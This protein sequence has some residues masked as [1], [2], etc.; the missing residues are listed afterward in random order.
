MAKATNSSVMKENNRRIILNL[1]R[2]GNYS[3]VDIARLTGLTKATV[4]ILTDEMLHQ[5]I[6]KE[7]ILSDYNSIGR[8]PVYLRINGNSKYTIGFALSRTGCKSGLYNLNGKVIVTHDFTY[9]QKTADEI[10]FDMVKKVKQYQAVIP[11][12]S[13]LGIGIASPGPVDYKKGIILNPPNFEKWHNYSI[14]EKLSELCKVPVVLENISNA[15]A[16]REMY[17]GSCVKDEN[18][19]YIAVDEGIGS[20]II[21]NGRIYRGENGYGNELGH[22]SIKYDGITCACGNKGCLECYAS[23]P[24][25]LKNTSYSSWRDVIDNNDTSIINREAEFLTCAIVTLINLFDLKTI[26]LGKD[27]NYK[28]DIIAK[29]INNSIKTRSIVKHPVEVRASLINDSSAGA[30]AATAIHKLFFEI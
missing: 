19:A 13:L 2:T 27:I 29:I 7:E 25:I 5:G 10:V 3:R 24:A 18:Y 4:T 1:I 12:G 14:C 21:I 15:L 9:S 6:I 22:T 23:I 11:S 20:G 17:F 28:G 26:I 16:L 8:R 30:A